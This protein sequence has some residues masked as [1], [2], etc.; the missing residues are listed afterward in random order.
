M[1]P[2]GKFRDLLLSGKFIVTAQACPPRGTDL[3]RFKETLSI[4]KEKVDAVVIPDGRGA[5]IQLGSTASAILA[6]D[7]GILP[8]VVFSCRDRNRIALCSDLMQAFSLGLDTVLCVTGDYVSFGD[9]PDAK[10]VYDLDSVQA[11]EMIQRME[12]GIDAGGNALEG[13]LSFCPGCA[14][15]PQASPF[16]PHLIKLQ[17]KIRAGAEFAFT[18]DVFEIEKARAFLE[19]IREMES[20]TIVGLR[21]LTEKDVVLSEKGMLTGNPVPRRLLESLGKTNSVDALKSESERLVA[22]L[23]ELR[24]SGLCQGVHIAMEGHEE[25]L[26]EILKDA[27]M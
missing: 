4:M 10:P 15:N 14:A 5:R 7:L 21:L 16:E 2:T 23:R 3:T 9:A 12:Q 11:L 6:R 24:A 19:R 1:Q 26:P 13:A 22:S 8:I 18:L 20:K 17:K 27:G 25:M